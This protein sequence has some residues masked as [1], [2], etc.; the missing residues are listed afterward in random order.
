[1]NAVGKTLAYPDVLR[2][3]KKGRG[4]FRKIPSSFKGLSLG[5]EN[6]PNI[7]AELQ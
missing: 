3:Q 2:W 5:G 1:M 7:F 4:S 6:I